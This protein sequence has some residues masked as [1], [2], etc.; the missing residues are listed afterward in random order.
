M[1]ERLVP[2][3]TKLPVG[4]YDALRWLAYRRR[5]TV[6]A[7]IASYVERCLLDEDLR[8]FVPSGEGEDA[9]GG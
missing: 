6:S 1:A 8:G 7:L 3:G 4:T 9:A 2:A 5:T